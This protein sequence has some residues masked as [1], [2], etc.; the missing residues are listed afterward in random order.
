MY[1]R[2]WGLGTATLFASVLVS[3]C[4]AATP[5]PTPAVT[6]NGTSIPGD[7]SFPAA[8]P[9]STVGLF[10]F[11]SS[12][13]P[14]VY[15]E[16]FDQLTATVVQSN[17]YESIPSV[18]GDALSDCVTQGTLKSVVL[19]DSSIDF[20]AIA[21]AGGVCSGSGVTPKP[22]STDGVGFCC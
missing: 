18:P 21:Y 10:N 1:W 15:M 13:V 7:I 17:G 9:E 4:G 6:T 2:G 5:A 14:G 20:A 8:T 3:A 12:K 11:R 19:I 22:R 16:V